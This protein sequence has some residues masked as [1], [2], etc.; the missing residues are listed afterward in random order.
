MVSI[1]VKRQIIG[2]GQ[3]LL[4]GQILALARSA[5]TQGRIRLIIQT[6]Y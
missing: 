2:L 1:A 5:L 3:V 6:P 4:F